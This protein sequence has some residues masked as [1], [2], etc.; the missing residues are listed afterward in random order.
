M[1][2]AL[3][4]AMLTAAL[5]TSHR[6]RPKYHPL[7]VAF[8]AT[9]FGILFVVAG[10]MGLTIGRSNWSMVRGTWSD[11]VVWWEIGYGAIALLFALHFWRKGLQ[12]ET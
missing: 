1:E 7:H 11:G 9:A 2:L 5:V 3:G 6:L 8:T 10:A 12:M 4:L